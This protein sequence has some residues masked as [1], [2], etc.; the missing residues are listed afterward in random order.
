[1]TKA[2]TASR[3]SKDILRAL[4]D[5]SQPDAVPWSSSDLRAMLEH[6]LAAPLACEVDRLAELARCSR[7]HVSSV[8]AE[9][10]CDTFADALRDGSPSASVLSMLKN[11]A[12]G[13][14]ASQGDLPRDV[15]RVLYVLAIVRGRQAGMDGITSLG[16]ANITRAVARCLTFGWLPDDIRD[17]LRG[18]QL[19]M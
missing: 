5:P 8:V 18:G 15:A 12:K 6:Q 1:M 2:P 7:E 17:L 19:G 14:M 4:M 11:C 13:A 10:G 16:E 3:K 9:C